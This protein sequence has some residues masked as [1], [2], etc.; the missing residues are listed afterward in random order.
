MFRTN[1]Y[2]P[3]GQASRSY[4]SNRLS[5]SAGLRIDGSTYSAEMANPLSNLSPRIS[6]SWSFNEKLSF[7]FNA[8]RYLQLP[9]YTSMGYAD[10][11][12]NF[13]N[14]ENGLS[15]IKSN[16]L[17]A[18]LEYQPKDNLQFTLE[19][20]YKQYS[21]YPFSVSDSVP[22]ASKSADYGIF[23]DEAVL[24]ISEGRSYGAEFLGRVKNF[25]GLNLVFSYTWVRS[26][27]KDINDNY[28]P[29]SWDNI[30]LL[31][32]TAT[33]SFGKNWDAGIK[34][35]FVGG[36]PYTPYDLEV[37]SL[38]SAWDVRGQGYLDYS[39]YNTERLK[40]FH[41]LDIRVDR[42][43]YFDNWSLMLYIDVQNV[44]NFKADQPA[45]LVRQSDSSGLPLTDP[46]DSDRYLLKYL[47]GESGTVL[48]TVGIIVEF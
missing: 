12:G 16:H 44:Y 20:F 30:H 37:S 39:N 22:L 32:L 18:G 45:I 42:A 33:R 19:G 25:D 48:P 11:A 24:S 43:F 47:V 31:N 4:L 3:F 23:G 15:F 5:L 8:G 41:Q 36:A 38:K 46:A 13:V 14:R 2:A 10:E 17:V 26:E 1:K 29:T 40:A 34:W 7:N 6:A 35:R 21:D 9:P 27:F 28:I